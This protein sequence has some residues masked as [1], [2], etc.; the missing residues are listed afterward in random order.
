MKNFVAHFIVVDGRITFKNADYVKVNLPK[1]NGMSGI[2]TIK[3]QWS[4]RSVSQNRYMWLCFEVLAQY[5]G[6]STE[7]VHTLCKGLYCPKKHVKVG[8]REYTMPKGT[9]ELTKGEMVEFMLGVSGLAGELGVVLPD[10]SEYKILSSMP[11]LINE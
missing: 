8:K 11:Y 7:E 5:T 2:V 4:K 10:P 9:S 1:Y 3:K 6:H